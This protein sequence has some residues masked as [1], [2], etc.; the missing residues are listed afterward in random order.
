MSLFDLATLD[1]PTAILIGLILITFYL[2][3]FFGRN[4]G[5][6]MFGGFGVTI[7]GFIIMMNIHTLIGF[8]VLMSGFMIGFGASE[9]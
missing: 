7:I 3:G 9:K 2:I 8:F 1:T 4:E 5:I 6:K